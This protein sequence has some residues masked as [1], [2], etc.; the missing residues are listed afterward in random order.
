MKREE[1]ER[2]KET[3]KSKEGRKKEGRKV[4]ENEKGRN[5]GRKEGG[6]GEKCTRS[7]NQLKTSLG[8]ESR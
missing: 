6:K 1:G 4:A 5:G 8:S 2:S 3:E 7:L